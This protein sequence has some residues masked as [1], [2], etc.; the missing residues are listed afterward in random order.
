MP[1]SSDPPAI[2][3]SDSFSFP[4]R[5]SSGKS[6]CPKTNA[7]S[8]AASSSDPGIVSIDN[9]IDP[10]SAYSEALT[11]IWLTILLSMSEGI[12]PTPDTFI[13]T[14]DWVCCASAESKAS[15]RPNSFSNSAPKDS[16]KV[17]IFAE[18]ACVCDE[19]MPILLVSFAN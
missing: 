4:P 5:M 6:C 15:S 10:S 3:V 18:T 2:A 1:E 19:D 13:D 8:A 11:A 16:K 17:F 12:I 9:L 7:A 14:V